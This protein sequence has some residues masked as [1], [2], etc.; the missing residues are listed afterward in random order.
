MVDLVKVVGQLY[1]RID[2]PLTGKPIVRSCLVGDDFKLYGY[3]HAMHTVH[4]FS[5]NINPTKRLAYDDKRIEK[6]L[7]DGL[8]EFE[9]GTLKREQ[10]RWP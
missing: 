9:D 4:P 1:Y 8:I 10:T 2:N 3:S 6:L 5:S 7:H